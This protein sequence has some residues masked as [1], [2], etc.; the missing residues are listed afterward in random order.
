MFLS[1]FKTVR[2]GIYMSTLITTTL[3][4]HK[5]RRPVNT[6]DELMPKEIWYFHHS[7]IKLVD[8]PVP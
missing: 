7:Q 6:R 1:L 3:Q 2:S 5:W 8:S 4:N